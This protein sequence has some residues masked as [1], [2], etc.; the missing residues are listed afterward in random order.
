MKNYYFSFPQT[1]LNDCLKITA[2]NNLYLTLL[3]MV[4]RA[5]LIPSYYKS[6]PKIRCSAVTIEIAAKQST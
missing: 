6:T 2:L 4:N 5:R 1:L 3:G